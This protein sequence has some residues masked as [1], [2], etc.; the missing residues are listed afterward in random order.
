MGH[1]PSDTLLYKGLYG[2]NPIP[3]MSNTPIV[4]SQWNVEFPY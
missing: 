3:L 4:W 2:I 1:I